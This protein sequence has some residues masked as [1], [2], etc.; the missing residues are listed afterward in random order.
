MSALVRS[1]LLKIRTTRSWWAYLTVIVLLTGIAAAGTVGSARGAE[2]DTTDFQLDLVDTIGIA[3][4]LAI[5]LGISIVTTEFRHGTI[6]PT[7]LAAP[8]RE[9]VLAAKT[10]AGVVVALGFAL[11]ALFVVAAVALPWLAIVDA[12]TNVGGGEIIERAGE[13]FLS[14]VLWL[15]LGVAIGAVVHSQVAAL[16]G[17]LIWIFLVETLLVVLFEWLDLNGVVPYL[18]FRALDAAD[19]TGGGELHSYA[20]G[21]AVSIAWIALIGGAGV[22]R[23]L[24]RDIS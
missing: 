4:I 19:G 9:R 13:Q 22:V 7:F 21:I 6:T 2:R 16:V 3:V 17:T 14:T 20:G 23:T 5:I 15:L 8:R 10:I 18:P 1:E 24:R 11:L 12:S